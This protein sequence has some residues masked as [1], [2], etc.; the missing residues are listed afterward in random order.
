MGKHPLIFW[1]VLKMTDLYIYI[2]F[3]HCCLIPSISLFVLLDKQIYF[4]TMYI[5]VHFRHRWV[6]LCAIVRLHSIMY[7]VSSV[8]NKQSK[9]S[10]IKSLLNHFL[11]AA[12]RV[13]SC[14]ITSFLLP[15]EWVVFRSTSFQVDIPYCKLVQRN[16]M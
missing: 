16:H 13:S 2:Y 6:Q 7:S 15:T 4:H 14:W 3:L 5:I 12:H 11:P 10:N 1:L 9:Q 8:T